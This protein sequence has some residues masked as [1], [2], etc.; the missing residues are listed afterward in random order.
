MRGTVLAPTH[1]S[2]QGEELEKMKKRAERFG[3]NV[4]PSLT[5]V[6]DNDKKRK[7]MERFGLTATD[8]SVEVME[9]SCCR[10]Y[11][12]TTR[13]GMFCR[14]GKEQGWNGLEPAANFLYTPC[15]YFML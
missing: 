10:P 4:A 5:A 8:L 13:C 9:V 11:W 14:I 7:R 1:P 12:V 3:S 2:I 6:E 15:Y